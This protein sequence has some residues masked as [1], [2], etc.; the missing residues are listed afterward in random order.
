MGKN[1][2][3]AERGSM[4]LRRGNLRTLLIIPAILF[5]SYNPK[6]FNIGIIIFFSGL[7]L[8]FIS[9]GFLYRNAELAVRGPYSFVRH[10]FYVANLILDT[11]IIFMSG[12]PVF[13]LIYL[14]LYYKSYHKTILEEE[15]N[16]INIYGNLYRDYMKAVP[17]YF[18]KLIPYAKYWH[19]G[20]KWENILRER[21]LS[22]LF[23]LI[24]YPI[25]FLIVHEIVKY[26]WHQPRTAL[27]L[28]GL[29]FVILLICVSYF[30]YN[31][32]ERKHIL[33][34]VSSKAEKD[35]H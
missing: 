15:S 13:I 31:M 7:L 8:H 3:K 17:K 4:R 25:S 29:G 18:P 1:G 34:N 14:F 11:G 20:F 32:V 28:S 26:K 2:E 22:R 21:E 35:S 16:L 10:P 23:R 33:K 30:T 12:Y 5:M 9:K 24:S 19:K 27:V 6:L